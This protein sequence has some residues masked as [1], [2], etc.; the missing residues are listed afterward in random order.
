M[1]ND[2]KKSKI[3]ARVERLN[4]HNSQFTMIQKPSLALYSPLP[5]ARSG[6]ADY[7]ADLL[8]A[9]A[10]RF[11]VTLF[12][13][14]PSQVTQSITAEFAVEPTEQ[15]PPFSPQSLAFEMHLYQLGNH[16]LH[17]ADYRRALDHP[18]VVVLHDYNLHAL[19][20]YETLGDRGDLHAYL[21]ALGYGRSSAELPALV[22]T[23]ERFR[24]HHA[25]PPLERFPLNRRLLDRS[26]GAITHSRYAADLIRADHPDLPLAVIPQLMSPYVGQDMRP[27]LKKEYGVTL[28]PET[29]ILA[30]AGQITPIKQIDFVLR[31]ISRLRQ[32]L[33]NIHL[34]LIGEPIEDYPLAQR[35][36]EHAV[37]SHVTVVGYTAGLNRFM[38]WIGTAD[39]LINL[40]YPTI[41][42]TSA[43]VLRGLACGVPA[44]VFD[45]GWY[46]EL[47][48]QVALKLPV[49]DDDRFLAGLH[50][51]VRDEPRRTAMSRAARDL[52]AT[53]HRPEEI[54]EQYA[55]FLA[56]LY[57]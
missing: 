28:E 17:M 4:V 49:M 18:G 10:N 41:G 52:I 45:H 50:A 56:Q 13:Q 12:A 20:E 31:A 11:E 3:A 37:S 2:E 19:V 46:S 47:P 38:D 1:M 8:P 32:Q 53:Q 27:V 16:A 44:V 22:R 9:L 39:L 33:P 54:A 30:A 23:A 7:T 5:P 21:R 29:I 43:T 6:I 57:R 51:L 40:R 26:L 34:L 36:D 15:Y 24:Y 55:R 35:I 14:D 48:D 25:R 42:E